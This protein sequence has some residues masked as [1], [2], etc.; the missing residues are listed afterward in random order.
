MVGSYHEIVYKRRSGRTGNPKTNSKYDDGL[1]GWRKLPI[2]SQ[3]SLY[4][5]EYDDEDNLIGMTQMPPPNFG[6]YTIPLER[7]SISGPD[8]EKEI[9]KEGVS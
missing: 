2:R 3:D 7:Q 9:Q 6:L 8:P 5:W 1:I 4:Q